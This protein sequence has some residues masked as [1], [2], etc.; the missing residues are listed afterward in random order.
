MLRPKRLTHLSRCGSP[1][2]VDV[3]EKPVS[4]RTAAAEAYVAV[5]PAVAALIRKT[6]AVAK[7]NVLET[8]RLAGIMAAKQTPAIV[9]LCH[10]IPL[11]RVDVEAR[12]EGDRVHIVATA[13]AEARTGVE[14]EAMTAAAA[15]A[16]TVYDM[17]KSAGKGAEIGPVRLLEKTGGRSGR[18]KREEHHRGPR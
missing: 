9:P 18:W 5:G 15:A 8:A 11:D 1:R 10:P 4:R 16:L 7:G 17:V 2:M 14:M 12:L 13:S 6:G 3:G